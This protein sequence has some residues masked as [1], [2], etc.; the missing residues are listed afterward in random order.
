MKTRMLRSQR[1]SYM[2]PLVGGGLLLAATAM[3]IP[4]RWQIADA[5]RRATFVAPIPV[6]VLP[7]PTTAMLMQRFTEGKR[8]SVPQLR[9]LISASSA[10][11]SASLLSSMAQQIERSG[12]PIETAQVTYDILASGRPD[13]A[14]AFLKSRPDVNAPSLWRLRLELHRKIGDE[15]GALDMLRAAAL[16]PGSAPAR[17]VTETAFALKRPDLMIIAAE[18]GAIPRLDAAQSLDLASWAHDEQR[19]DLIAKI[20]RAGTPGWR[21]KNPW[22]A[23]TLALQAGDTAAALRY[24]TLLP[25]GRDAARESILLGSGDLEAVRRLLLDRAAKGKEDRAAIAQLLLEK[26]FRPDAI[27]LLR[28]QTAGRATND[29]TS[30]RML[31]LMGPRPG[32]E[33]LGWL[34]TRAAADP[35]WLASY[36]EREQPAKALAFLESRPD[37]GESQML[38]RRIGLASAARDEQGIARA[39]D[40]LLDG[41]AL[42][43]AQ[44]KAASG[45]LVSPALTRRYALPL[46]RARIAAGQ[47]LGSDR[48]DLAWDAWNK[49]DA[50]ATI[51]Q[52]DA[53]LRSDPNDRDALR[54]MASA[55]GKV[56]GAAGER[57]WLKRLLVLSPPLS[58]DRAELLAKL[59]QTHDAIAMFERLRQQS[60]G[61][62]QL[63]IQLSRLLIAAGDPGRARKVLQP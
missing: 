45:A 39:L 3:L 27:G 26:G 49:G 23:M 47:G 20:D 61:D 40:G 22:L 13:E 16:S 42:N 8:L 41:R 9:H 25:S 38:V 21:T 54:L 37:A 28:E 14:L 15:T 11:A 59:G 19:Y 31:Y 7:P 12:S 46:S 29:T 36:L 1:M 6:T 57:P 10:T 58:R 53:H 4:N 52:L 48:M 24:A 56:G 43:E 55:Q 34:K 32:A 35:Q 50:A 17:D 30:Q 51:E 2:G 62:R 63:D 44:L 33:D 18:N 5:I 60:P